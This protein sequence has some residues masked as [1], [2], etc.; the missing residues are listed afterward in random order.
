MTLRERNSKVAVA[1]EEVL[2]WGAI[3]ILSEYVPGKE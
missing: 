3:V 2:L 1:P